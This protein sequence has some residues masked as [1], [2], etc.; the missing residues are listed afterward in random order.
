MGP[1][2]AT[3]LLSASSDHE[4]F[5]APEGLWASMQGHGD[6]TAPMARWARELAG[7]YLRWTQAPTDAPTLHEQIGAR[8]TAIDAWIHGQLPPPVPGVPRGTDSVGGVVARVAEAWACAHWTLHQDTDEAQRHRIWE[9]LAEMQQGY[10]GLTKLALNGLI[11]L[12]K[13]WPG[14]G[15]PGHGLLPH[16]RK[17]GARTTPTTI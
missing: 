1:H 3:V 10:E 16:E 2:A 14:L 17:P 8:I 9:H 13:S 6:Y 7:L 15:W 12:P 5:L 4:P 11:I